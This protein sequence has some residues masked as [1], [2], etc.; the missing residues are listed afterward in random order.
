[1]KRLVAN[2]QVNW[3]VTFQGG[4]PLAFSSAERISVSDKNPHTVDLYFDTNQFVP[5]RRRRASR[6]ART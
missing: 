6:C 4:A 2:R 3:A 5:Q 1:M